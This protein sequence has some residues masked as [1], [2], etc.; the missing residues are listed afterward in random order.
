MQAGRDAE[1]MALRSKLS[2]AEAIVGAPEKAELF[3]KLHE[4]QTCSWG[5]SKI[6]RVAQRIDA[7][8]ADFVSTLKT[9]GT[10]I[11]TEAFKRYT[12]PVINGRQDTVEINEGFD[13]VGLIEYNDEYDQVVEGIKTSFDAHFVEVMEYVKVLEPHKAIFLENE[14]EFD[15]AKHA[16]AELALRVDSSTIACGN[17]AA[18]SSPCS[19]MGTPCDSSS[20]AMKLRCIRSRSSLT[21]GSSVGPSTPKFIDRLSS[22][23]SRPSSPLASLCFSA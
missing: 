22:A 20:V 4:L 21:C 6:G 11:A 12:Q 10:L 2:S 1:T 13:I 3:F 14:N 16:D 9:V 18:S 7:T 8:I 5:V 19:S 17:A 15:I 23:P